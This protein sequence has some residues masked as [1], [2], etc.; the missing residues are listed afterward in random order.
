MTFHEKNVKRNLKD[1][2]NGLF[3]SDWY[4]KHTPFFSY[5]LKRLLLKHFGK[6]RL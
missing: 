5:F 3:I 4:F 2:I 1:Q 6:F